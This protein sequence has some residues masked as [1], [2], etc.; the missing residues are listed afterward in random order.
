MSALLA[1]ALLV[2]HF[3]VVVFVVGGLVV[4]WIGAAAGWRWVRNPWFRYAHL[5]AIAAI[6]AESVLGYACPLTVWEDILRG[7]AR[8]ESFVGRWVARA[9]YYEAPQWA[10]TSLYLLWTAASLVTLYFVPCRARIMPG[11]ARPHDG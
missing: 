11:P 2:V 7:H 1:D 3:A 8:P 6:A 5:L 9:L 4:V 10:F